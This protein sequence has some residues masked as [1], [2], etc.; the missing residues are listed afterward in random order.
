MDIRC[1]VTMS[2]ASTDA[3]NVDDIGTMS[4]DHCRLNQTAMSGRPKVRFMDYDTRTRAGGLRFIT[5]QQCVPSKHGMSSHVVYG[6]L[7][8]RLWSCGFDPPEPL[9]SDSWSLTLQRA[10]AKYSCVT[11]RN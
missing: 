11:V 10:R 4:S 6:A 9:A 2:V 8:R 3:L 5:S 1:G 7:A